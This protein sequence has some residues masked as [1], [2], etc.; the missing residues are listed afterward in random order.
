MKK[1]KIIERKRDINRLA[2]V[3]RLSPE[4]LSDIFTYVAHEDIDHSSRPY[5]WLQ[6]TH[7]CHEWKEIA[8]AAPRVWN[9]VKLTSS[10]DCL[11]DFI[12]R[13]KQAPLHIMADHAFPKVISDHVFG[14]LHRIQTLSLVLDRE[15]ADIVIPSPLNAPELRRLKLTQCGPFWRHENLRSL[16]GDL[17]L[18][19]IM[20][21]ELSL[22]SFYVDWTSP[23]FSPSLTNLSIRGPCPPDSTLDDVLVALAGMPNL[24]LIVLSGSL[25]SPRQESGQ[26]AHLPYLEKLDVSDSCESCNALVRRITCPPAA[27]L[28]LAIKSFT[29]SDLEE[30]GYMV[31]AKLSN[32]GLRSA[33]FVSGPV[34][35]TNFHVWKEQLRIAKSVWDNTYDTEAVFKLHFGIARPLHAIFQQAHFPSPFLNVRTLYITSNI[36]FDVGWKLISDSM[37]HV[38]ELCVSGSDTAHGPQIMDMLT[39][40]SV[41]PGSPAL[42]PLFP[43][44]KIF[45]LSD[46]YLY[47]NPRDDT[48]IT[49]VGELWKMLESRKLSHR[50]IEEL[51][52]QNIGC[53]EI[54]GGDF[55]DVVGEV[56]I[57]LLG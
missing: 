34:G 55:R 10:I 46:I 44:L 42:P 43:R 38:S 11:K 35:S 30:L 48:S 41:T 20:D 32:R 37:P 51:R 25:P 33:S 36:G 22:S 5:A 50:M 3:S 57:R 45:S 54:D 29:E 13:S 49:L 24:K 12:A 56:R 40:Q 14:Q 17:D 52:L 31:C 15:I 18:P 7:V 39:V 19:K 6:A 8:Q 1:Q 23:I 4:I 47:K 53:Y 26:A 16:F 9:H 2:P 21:L 28:R 27:V